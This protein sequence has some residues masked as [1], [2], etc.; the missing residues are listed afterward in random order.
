MEISDRVV[1]IEPARNHL[2]VVPQILADGEADGLVSDADEIGSRLGRA[3]LEITAFVENVVS[4]QERFKVLGD[5]LAVAKQ[6]HGVTQRAADGVGIALGESDDG[7]DPADF[8]GN[9]PKGREVI[10]DKLG[11]QEQVFGRIAD[12]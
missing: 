1:V 8:G 5:D 3:R 6:G 7:V 10:V 11:L 2:F 12:D 9:A 4:G